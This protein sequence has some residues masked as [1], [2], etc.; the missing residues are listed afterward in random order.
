[1]LSD[2]EKRRILDE[3]AALYRAEQEAQQAEARRREGDAYR[4]KVRAA[5][6]LKPPRSGWLMAAL[7]VWVGA[8]LLIVRSQRPAVPDDTAGGIASSALINRCERQLLSQLGQLA[9]Q[10]P[11]EQEAARQITA[12]SDGKRWDGWVESAPTFSGRAD[13]SCV[14]SPPTDQ[15]QVELLGAE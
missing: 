15:I 8:A 13:F 14:Y 4:S 11:D 9:A 10:F 2:E 6:R 5:Y 1:M 3:E 7:I 12:N